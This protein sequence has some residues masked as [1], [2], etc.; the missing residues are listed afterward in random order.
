M[1]IAASDGMA[2]CVAGGAADPG[3]VDTETDYVMHATTERWNEM[4]GGEYGPMR[5]MMFGR[6][7]FSGPKWEAMKNMGPF[8]N[9]L[10]IVG[11]VAA[12]TSACP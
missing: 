10:L 2:K 6:L 12:D 4:G 8:E 5:A 7:K 11:Q 1:R 9:F 3:G